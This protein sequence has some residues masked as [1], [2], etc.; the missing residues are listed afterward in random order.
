MRVFLTA[1]LV[2]VLSG[3]GTIQSMSVSNIVPENKN[4]V[5]AEE[6]GTGILYLSIPDLIIAD[7]LRKQCPNGEVNGV[8][9][10]LTLRNFFIFQFYKLKAEGYCSKL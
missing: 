9:T 7:K 3:C 8:Q 10:R 1:L 6:T 4:I 2:L 5:S